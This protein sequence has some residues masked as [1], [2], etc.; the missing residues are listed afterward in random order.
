M[1]LGVCV[2]LNVWTSAVFPAFATCT[3]KIGNRSLWHSRED[4]RWRS[5]QR[6]WLQFNLLNMNHLWSA[7]SRFQRGD[8]RM[9]QMTCW[10]KNESSEARR[11]Q[12]AWLYGNLCQRWLI[13]R[14]Q[15]HAHSRTELFLRKTSLTCSHWEVHSI[16]SMIYWLVKHLSY[17][18]TFNS[19]NLTGSKVVEYNASLSSGW[20]AATIDMEIKEISLFCQKSRPALLQFARRDVVINGVPGS[21]FIS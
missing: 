16:H 15:S 4:N 13:R 21:A 2:R 14:E 10:F 20:R 8:D 5:I 19:I 18:L 12:L 6:M 17:T 7:A 1:P 11:A 9:C 3:L